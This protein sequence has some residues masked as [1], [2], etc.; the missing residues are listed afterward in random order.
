MNDQ[1]SQIVDLL[2]ETTFVI[3]NNAPTEKVFDIIKKVFHPGF[4]IEEK[5]DFAKN[6]LKSNLF[7]VVDRYGN[8]CDFFEPIECQLKR[9]Q[10]QIDEYISK[11]KKDSN[12]N[13][14]VIDLLTSL[15]IYLDVS[16]GLNKNEVN[17]SNNSKRKLSGLNET[18]SPE[19]KRS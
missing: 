16:F 5:I 8:F 3:S 4:T 12:S 18:R 14:R 7:L 15:K 11:L 19:S 2:I 10:K 13:E 1:Q 9:K 6:V 17:K